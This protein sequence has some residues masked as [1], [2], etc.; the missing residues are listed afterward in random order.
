M[1][2]EEGDARPRGLAP[3]VAQRQPDRAGRR[4]DGGQGRGLGPLGDARANGHVL[5][6]VGEG[7][8]EREGQGQVR[9]RARHTEVPRP[10]L[11][12]GPA[13]QGVAAPHPQGGPSK[14]QAE[15]A[16]RR[17][18]DDV[19][20]ALAAVRVLR[21]E[22]VAVH[23]DAVDRVGRGQGTRGQALD[24]D[25]VLGRAGEARPGPRVADQLPRVVRDGPELRA[26]DRDGGER[27]VGGEPGLALARPD[28]Q[29]LVDPGE[30]ES[31][32]HVRRIADRLCPRGVEAGGARGDRA[33]RGPLGPIEAERP[34]RV[35]PALA[36]G[37]SAAERD[38]GPHHDP[39]LRIHDP[40]LE[41]RGVSGRRGAARQHQGEAERQPHPARR[42]AR[43]EGR[44]GTTPPGLRTGSGRSHPRSVRC[45]RT[46][47][48]RT[49][50]RRRSSR[51]S[52]PWGL[53]SR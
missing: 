44:H 42:A 18:R 47:W 10:R 52:S 36:R 5:A 32:Q 23:D 24:V 3:G 13:V 41:R 19:D 14:A 21:R 26:G 27:P 37:R 48:P 15:P 7:G 2:S 35:R 25:V 16:V 50:S 38:D 40:S 4:G 46:G 53:S 31:D 11:R 34:L 51:P 30:R 20:V 12:L 45:C 22:R 9:H 43:S 39:V 8:M 6:I 1:R 28:G 17:G 29:R 33:A 49:A